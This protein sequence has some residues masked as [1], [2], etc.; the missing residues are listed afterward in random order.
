MACFRVPVAEAM[1]TTV[2][3]KAVKSKE[4]EPATL[5]VDTGNGGFERIYIQYADFLILI[6]FPA[7]SIAKR[8]Y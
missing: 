7:V 5:K 6:V 8:K 3:T 2:I 4:T 1:V